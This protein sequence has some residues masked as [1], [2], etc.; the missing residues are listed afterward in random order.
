MKRNREIVGLKYTNIMKD[1]PWME[2][3][4]YGISHIGPEKKVL[5]GKYCVLR[6]QREETVVVR[7]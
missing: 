1:I 2:G 5:G 7:R 3:Q 6:R 4:N